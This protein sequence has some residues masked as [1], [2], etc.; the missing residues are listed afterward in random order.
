MIPLK[1]PP[2]YPGDEAVRKAFGRAM[3]QARLECGLSIEQA[4]AAI[5]EGLRPD[6]GRNKFTHLGRA[7]GI[8]VRQL[9]ERK[10]MTR[11]QLASNSGLPLRFIILVER[12]KLLSGGDIC[13]LTRLAY[14][15]KYSV[16]QFFDELTDLNEELAVG[17]R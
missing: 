10:G 5:R 6:E 4:E 17:A 13:Q 15:L 1:D 9:R 8:F 2:G 14:G 3:K 12:G 7:L 16:G 11:I